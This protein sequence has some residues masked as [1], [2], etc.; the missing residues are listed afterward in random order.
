M[1][2]TLIIVGSIVLLILV[3]FMYYKSTYDKA[4]KLDEGVMTAWSD[5]GADYQRRAD[6]IPGLI[7]TVKGAAENEKDI[8]TAVTNAR[9]GI[10]GAKTPEEM[11]LAGKKINAAINL[12]FEAYPQI[13]STE[14]F[15]VF[16]AQL[17]GTE[18]RINVSRKKYNESVK[19]YNSHVRSLIPSMLIGGKFPTKE[20]FKES[21][22]SEVAPEVKF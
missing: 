17:E 13:R 1:K 12:A 6:L 4:V 3:V 22:G 5:V 15:G 21:A 10:V 9:A 16:Q 7:E 14:N 18:N 2:K 20:P 19:L 8:L 11:E